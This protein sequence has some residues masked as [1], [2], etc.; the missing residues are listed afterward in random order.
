MT[1]YPKLRRPKSW[2]KVINLLMVQYEEGKHTGLS[3]NCPLCRL[4]CNIGGK[5]TNLKSE[6]CHYCPWIVFENKICHHTPN[7][8]EQSITDRIKRLRRWKCIIS[9]QL[10]KGVEK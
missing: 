8:L 6:F 2:L 4:V 10:K 5:D 9:K 7:Y 1:K 3:G